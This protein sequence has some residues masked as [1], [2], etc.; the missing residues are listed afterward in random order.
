MSY[1]VLDSETSFEGKAIRVRID[2]V[3]HSSGRSMRIELIEHV[4]SVVMV[5]IDDQGQIWFVR[6]Y[7]HP[8][9]QRLLELP[10]GTLD[11]GERPQDCAVRECREEIGMSPG[12]L[13][14]LGGCFLDPGYSSEF[15]RFYLAEDLSPDPLTLDA[16]EDLIVER[17]AIDQAFALFKRGEINDAKTIV[18]LSLA[19]SH[20]GKLKLD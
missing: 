14:D 3:R 7:R 20:L 11:L 2:D 15:A 17:M 1:Q 12:R 8:A 16:D 19:L 5:P 6:Q 10:A 4:G 13:T 9:A 18:G